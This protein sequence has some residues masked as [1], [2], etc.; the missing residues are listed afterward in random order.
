MLCTSYGSL[1]TVI[2]H[3][4]QH[5][6]KT[7]TKMPKAPPRKG[8]P[9][10]HGDVPRVVV[11]HAAPAVYVR[12]KPPVNM[13]AL[14]DLQTIRIDAKRFA[15]YNV[16]HPG[17]SDKVVYDYLRTK[18]GKD[19]KAIKP[20]IMNLVRPALAEAYSSMPETAKVDREMYKYWAGTAF[21]ASVD[22]IITHLTEKFGV[23]M[24]HLRD[25]IEA[26]LRDDRWLMHH[27]NVE[28]QEHAR[29]ELGLR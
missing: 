21:D 24:K 4:E 9:V 15:H 18:Y 23:D 25:M 2:H 12:P 19:I 1:Y 3:A 13:F 11:Q 16:M 17:L 22:D 20:T 14:P 5:A 27:L 7:T 26:N 6:I 29:N 28:A 8:V 10:R